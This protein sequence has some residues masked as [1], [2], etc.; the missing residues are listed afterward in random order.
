MDIPLT[1][2]SDLV[3]LTPVKEEP[4]LGGLGSQAVVE[5]AT[6]T[7]AY[8]EII[9]NGNLIGAEAAM[10]Y[11]PGG[12]VK[13][14][15][16]LFVHPAWN[17]AK[18]KHRYIFLEFLFRATWAPT[19][20]HW[21][22]KR[23]DLSIGQLYFSR[24]NLADEINKTCHAD[25]RITEADIRGAIHYFEKCVF[26]TRHLASGITNAPTV[27]TIV[28]SGFCSDVKN[29][30]NQA[31]NQASNQHLAS[32]S[33]TKE[34]DKE[35]K[36]EYP[37]LT[38]S[39][40][41]T[42]LPSAATKDTPKISKKR[43]RGPPAERIVRAVDVATTEMQHQDLIKT[44]GEEGLNEVY[45]AYAI[46][47]NG[48]GFKGGEDFKTLKGWTLGIKPVAGQSSKEPVEQSKPTITQRLKGRYNYS[49]EFGMYEFTS[50]TTGKSVGKVPADD[51]DALEEW[52]K[53][54]NL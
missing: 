30:S 9:P 42:V 50:K 18:P 29:T 3:R 27:L 19:F 39:P 40:E 17:S 53:E 46:W 48:V 20:F 31:S 47:K 36:E 51:P 12:F 5:F 6:P 15:R 23:I 7:I 2:N 25:E 1:T 21:N 38:V 35:H 4:S 28:F 16:S 8:P 45:K 32:V 22:G 44:H 11:S 43:K 54:K 10:S 41:T 34:E 52:F 24:K 33:P 13:I 14:P 49:K 26:L 37:S